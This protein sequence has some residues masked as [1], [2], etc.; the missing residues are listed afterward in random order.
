MNNFLYKALV[1]VGL[2]FTPLALSQESSPREQDTLT[3]QLRWLP[4]AQFLGYYVADTLGF[5]EQEGISLSILPGGP[6]VKP[7]E[8][9]SEGSVDIAVE[10]LSSALESRERGHSPVN[11]AQILQRSSLMII[12]KKERGIKSKA[13]LTNKTI[14][15]WSGSSSLGL[16][17]WLA[18]LE[19][20]YGRK[21]RTIELTEQGEAMA[22]WAKSS[23]DCISATSYNEYWQLLDAG[24]PLDEVVIFRF[25]NSANNLLEDG[26]YVDR[27]RLTDP[28]FVNAVTRFTRASLAG[29][30][31]TIER[32][33]EAIEI[34]LQRFPDLDRVHQTRMTSEIIRL[35]DSPDEPLGR[36]AV[37][38]FESQADFLGYDTASSSEASSPT[39][40]AWSHTIWRMLDNYEHSPLSDEVLYRLEKVLNLPAFYL[41]DL[42]GTL[43]FGLAGFARASERQYDIWGAIILTALPAVGGGS[44]RD[45]L[46]GGDRQTPFIFSDPN[47]L[48][49][50]FGIVAVGSLWDR[51]GPT[52]KPLIDRNSSLFL[53]ID[54]VGLAAFSIVGAKV[55]IVAQLDWFWIPM[56]AAISCAGGGVMMD[57]VS[58]REPRTFRGVMYEEIAI[59]GGLVLL[60]LLYLAQYASN[61]ELFIQ[62][63]IV[64]TFILVY[65]LRIVSVQ[66]DWTAPKLG[67]R[68]V[69][70]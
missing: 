8:L 51:I 11:V 37:E 56:M 24:L 68:L 28:A 16:T 7:V 42:L 35:I 33:S 69:S 18:S 54:T 2:F 9:L 59:L 4:Q 1:L 15:V 46:V 55:A 20:Q 41:L 53:A 66:M 3:L 22:S 12:C 30:E 19:R 25:E 52:G 62:A 63:A 13:D 38:R 17:R 70:K 23:T 10:W 57:I 50:V 60:A 32:P 43:A 31:F 36:L 40:G 67:A 34:L 29:W 44:L 21:M 61:V 14:S 49:I 27:G 64:Q 48:Y 58:G 47:Y 39:K 65:A 6:G 45:I 5:Y 26:L